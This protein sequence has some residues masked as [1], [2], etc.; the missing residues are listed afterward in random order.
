MQD[1]YQDP[2]CAQME[3]GE[4][5]EG[6]GDCGSTC[7][8]LNHPPSMQR[9]QMTSDD[10]SQGRKGKTTKEDQQSRADAGCGC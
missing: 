3:N 5:C 7:V 1:L 2:S 6:H 8:L 9:R 4:S 10:L